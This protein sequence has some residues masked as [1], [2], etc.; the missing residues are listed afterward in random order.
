MCIRGWVCTSGWEGGG[1]GGLMC[2]VC[3]LLPG[4]RLLQ[5]FNGMV[6]MP[7]P[8]LLPTFNCG[9]TGFVHLTAGGPPFPDGSPKAGDHLRKIFYRMGFS[10]Q[11]IVA[12]SGIQ[13]APAFPGVAKESLLP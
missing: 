10:D 9:L 4:G 1:G 11:E 6:C 5:F 13:Q 3:S 12:L 2:T 7:S 8:L